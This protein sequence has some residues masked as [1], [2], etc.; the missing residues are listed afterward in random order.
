[1]LGSQENWRFRRQRVNIKSRERERGVDMGGGDKWYVE[2]IIQ[3]VCVQQTDLHFYTMERQTKEKKY[4]TNTQHNSV[5]LEGNK[6][7]NST[8]N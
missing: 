2:K 5:N 3:I 8:K 4:I 6:K 1:M 7:T